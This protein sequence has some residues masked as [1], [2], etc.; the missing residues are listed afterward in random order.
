MQITHGRQSPLWHLR[1]QYLR[2]VGIM[3]HE[4]VVDV[5]RHA[6]LVDGKSPHRLLHAVERGRLPD[7]VGRK[8]VRAVDRD[9]VGPFQFEG[10]L[11]RDVW[12]EAKRAHMGQCLC[13]VAQRRRSQRRLTVGHL[14]DVAER[15]PRLVQ[16][17]MVPQPELVTDRE[18]HFAR[19]ELGQVEPGDPLLVETHVP[20]NDEPFLS[21]RL[22]QA[23]VVVGFDLDERAKDVLVLVGVLVSAAAQQ[24]VSTESPSSL[25]LSSAKVESYRRRIG[26]GSSS[27]PG[28]SRSSSV[29]LALSRQSSSSLL[30]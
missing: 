29:A 1:T 4:F 5:T 21:L 24:R 16:L 15:I 14:D 25:A 3:P 22:F 8:V 10:D 17:T 6:L 18:T 20:A 2:R 13:E 7:K 19:L 27:T 9:V 30:I 12:L 26:C 28:F 11:V 23:L